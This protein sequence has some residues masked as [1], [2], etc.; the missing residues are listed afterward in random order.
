MFLLLCCIFLL[1]K[2]PRQCRAVLANPFFKVWNW[3]V[4]LFQPNSP[5][6]KGNS[7]A[8]KMENNVHILKTT[9]YSSLSFRSLTQ[10]T[11]AFGIRYSSSPDPSLI[12]F[13]ESER[14]GRGEGRAWQRE[15][16]TGWV[17]QRWWMECRRASRSR[18]SARLRR[19]SQQRRGNTRGEG[20]CGLWLNLQTEIWESS[21]YIHICCCVSGIKVAPCNTIYS[22]LQV[23]ASRKLLQRSHVAHP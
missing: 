8:Q 15:E 18:L 1:F 20:P 6:K 19:W 2:T 4:V 14:R 23:A 5:A 9:T 16:E 17:A 10:L 22:W 11:W 13:S 21:L 12:W 7:R 3:C